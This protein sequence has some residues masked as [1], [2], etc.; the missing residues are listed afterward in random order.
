M[1]TKLH[2]KSELGTARM[3]AFHF[4]GDVKD[5]SGQSIYAH[6]FRISQK[7]NGDTLKT[8]AMLHDIVEDSP[9]TLPFLMEFF[10]YRVIKA[11]DILTRRENEK[12]FDYIDRIITS[13]S[14]IAKKVKFADLR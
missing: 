6:S 10:S 3:L 13:G 1:L 4:L 7:V 14:E 11:V 5:K 2:G 12:Y 8:V 9:I